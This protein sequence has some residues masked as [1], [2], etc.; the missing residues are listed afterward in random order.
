M[1]ASLDPAAPPSV[2]T[3]IYSTEGEA[4]QMAACLTK[5]RQIINSMPGNFQI[6]DLSNFGA[7]ITADDVRDSSTSRVTSSY[8]AEF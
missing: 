3:N 2:G 8:I 1:L 5:E 6:G 4:E 7:D